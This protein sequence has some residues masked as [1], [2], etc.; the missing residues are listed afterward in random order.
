MMENWYH[1]HK[2]FL[3]SINIDITP[4]CDLFESNKECQFPQFIDFY[5]SVYPKRY[6]IRRKIKYKMT[7]KFSI[8]F[9]FLLFLFLKLPWKNLVRNFSSHCHYNVVKVYK[10]WQFSFN[11]ILNYDSPVYGSRISS[12]IKWNLL[13]FCN[14][15]MKF[16][17]FHEFP[18]RV[19]MLFMT[20]TKIRRKLNFAFSFWIPS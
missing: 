10:N 14:L 4:I 3:I 5:L 8:S 2:V 15:F 7:L 6:S 17:E 20:I 12:P 18:L 19:R 13:I 9:Y 11:T 16:L 1:S